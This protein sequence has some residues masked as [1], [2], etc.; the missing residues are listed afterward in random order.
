MK[1]LEKPKWFTRWIRTHHVPTV[2]DGLRWHQQ[3]VSYCQKNHVALNYLSARSNSFKGDKYLKYPYGKPRLLRALAVEPFEWFSLAEVPEAYCSMIGDLTFDAG[4]IARKGALEL[5]CDV[6]L[7]K[8]APELATSM[9]EE[10]I[11]GIVIDRDLSYLTAE[12]N[13]P[14][15]FRIN[16]DGSER[17]I[18]QYASNYQVTSSSERS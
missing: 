4:F 6:Q 5:I 9:V 1:A 18:E 12:G 7:A 2:V 10:L 11:D 14:V 13:L 3:I 16:Y 17:F 8:H 15:N